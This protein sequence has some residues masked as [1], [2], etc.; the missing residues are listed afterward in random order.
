MKKIIVLSFLILSTF[1][2]GQS[3]SVSSFIPEPGRYIVSGWV[4]EISS[5]QKQQYQSNISV[6][7]SDSENAVVNSYI[8]LPD[9]NIIDGWQQIIG[10]IEVSSQHG[11]IEIKLVNQSFGI[12][13]F[14]DIR[15]IP[16]NANMKSFAYDSETLRLMAEL[17]ENNY[18]TFYEYDPEGGLI[19]VKKETERGVFTIQE[20]RSNTNKKY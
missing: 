12:A 3:T 20:T 10:E 7:L 19:R 16:F 14:D 2:H 1:V 5:T 4:K 18:A 13:C 9:G 11:F 17:D 6:L 8:F 15:F